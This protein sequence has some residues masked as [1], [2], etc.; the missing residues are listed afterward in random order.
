MEFV[1]LRSILDYIQGRNLMPVQ[2]RMAMRSFTL[3]LS[4][5]AMMSALSVGA[6]A[7]P[8]TTAPATTTAMQPAVPENDPNKMVCRTMAAKTGS[9]IGASRECRTQREWDDIRH[10]DEHEIEKMQSRDNLAPR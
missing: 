2:R 1:V 10:Q 5:A 7:D 4:S 8:A 9:R 6:V 3:L